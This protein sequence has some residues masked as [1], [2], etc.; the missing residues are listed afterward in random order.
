MAWLSFN[1]SSFTDLVYRIA[2]I[3]SQCSIFHCNIAS[4]VAEKHRAKNLFIFLLFFYFSSQQV[5]VNSTSQNVVY[6][7]KINLC[8]VTFHGKVVFKRKMKINKFF[9]FKLLWSK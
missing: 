3:Y 6:L 2:C 8:H 1:G 5:E 7:V 9:F 4:T